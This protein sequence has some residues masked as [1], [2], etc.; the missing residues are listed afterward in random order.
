MAAA[1]SVS[2]AIPAAGRIT[3]GSFRISG[4]DRLGFCVTETLDS[5]CVEMIEVD[6]VVCW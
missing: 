3:N 6:I 4:K 5:T 1:T 2:A